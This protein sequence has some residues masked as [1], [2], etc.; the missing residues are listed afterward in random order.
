[1]VSCISFISLSSI[2]P[3]MINLFICVNKESSSI[4]MM[5]V[6]SIR[7][8]GDD[9]SFCVPLEFVDDFCGVRYLLP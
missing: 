7:V 6:R 5:T 2:I 1:M 3:P 8:S 4:R 9:W